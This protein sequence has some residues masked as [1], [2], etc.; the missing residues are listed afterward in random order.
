MILRRVQIHSVDSRRALCRIREYVISS[1]GNGQH[2]IF[3]P[4]IEQA[5]IRSS[6]FPRKGVNVLV[7][8]LCVLLKLIVIVDTPVMVL[9]ERRGQ[10]QVCR[11]VLSRSCKSPGTPFR[12]KSRYRTGESAILALVVGRLRGE[13][14]NFLDN[15]VGKKRTGKVFLMA[16]DPYVVGD[17][18]ERQVP[19]VYIENSAK[20]VL[21]IVSATTLETY[22]V[23]VE[24]CAPEGP[25]EPIHMTSERTTSVVSKSKVYFR[26][27]IEVDDTY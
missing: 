15:L 21:K 6:I 8:E 14:I 22:P 17:A 20:F 25:Q 5:L 18:T 12:C 9:I 4:Q 27:D 13:S 7:V 1:A 3:C 16:P 11:N 23:E 26:L 19:G 10:G 24:P 2:Y